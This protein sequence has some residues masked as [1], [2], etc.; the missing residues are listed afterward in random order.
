MAGRGRDVA[1][2]EIQG[3]GSVSGGK[4]MGCRWTEVNEE[5]PLTDLD[6]VNGTD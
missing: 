5:R 2:V 3:R 6:A 1:I 4:I